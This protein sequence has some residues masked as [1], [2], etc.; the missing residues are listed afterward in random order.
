MTSDQMTGPRSS[1]MEEW[2]VRHLIRS[3]VIRSLI[4]KGLVHCVNI[5]G[6]SDSWLDALRSALVADIA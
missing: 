6:A 1:E 5:A 4:P 2:W 3:P